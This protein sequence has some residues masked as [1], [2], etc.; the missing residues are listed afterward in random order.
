M[1]LYGFLSSNVLL[2]CWRLSAKNEAHRHSLK[3]ACRKLTELM[4]D[5]R[6]GLSS[7]GSF[8][9]L[10]AFWYGFLGHGDGYP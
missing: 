3:L 9:C 4:A 2:G 7:S 10:V 6:E 8:P 5:C 1:N